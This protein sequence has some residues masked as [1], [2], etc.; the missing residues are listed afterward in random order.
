MICLLDLVSAPP[1]IFGVNASTNLHKNQSGVQH[2]GVDA[3][4]RQEDVAEDELCDAHA[5]WHNKW[6]IWQNV[7]L[8]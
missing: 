6:T 2:L 8:R 1:D 3:K 7:Q 4:W 5:L